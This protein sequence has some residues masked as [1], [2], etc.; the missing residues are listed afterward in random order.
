M[1]VV[2]G[3]SDLETCLFLVM[4]QDGSRGVLCLEMIFLGV[5]F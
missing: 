5:V 3:G 1:D 4:D 2:L